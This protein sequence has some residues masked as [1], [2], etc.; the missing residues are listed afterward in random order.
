MPRIVGL[1]GGIASGKSTVSTEWRKSPSV[2]VIDADAV[3]RNAVKPGSPALW[4]IRRRFGRGVIHADGT[5]NR[6][7][8]GRIIFSDAAERRALNR[9]MHPFIIAEMLAR[10]FV[11]AF[12]K[13]KPIIVLDTPLLFESRTLIPFC[14][15]IVVVSCTEEQQ[16]KRM[17]L[18]DGKAKALSEEDALARLRSQMPL[19][20]KV[21]KAHVVIDN[22]SDIATVQ[23]GAREALEHLRPSPVG[24]F[25]FRTLV[26]T[27]VYKIFVSLLSCRGGSD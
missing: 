4:L 21:E 20:E 3:A 6:A 13:W 10:L 1:T 14:S 9:R 17:L 2:I 23:Q 16:L 8:L 22:S 18:R 5:L 24:E 11:A 7:A 25:V 19:R 27:A 12:V 15:R 26:C